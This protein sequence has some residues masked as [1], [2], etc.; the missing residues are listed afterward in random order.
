MKSIKQEVKEILTE[1]EP[2]RNFDGS[3]FLESCK[4]NNVR[5]IFDDDFDITAF[6]NRFNHMSRQRR[7]FQMEKFKDG[8]L[9]PDYE[10]SLVATEKVQS[11]RIRLER[12]FSD[13][14]SANYAFPIEDR[15]IVLLKAE[16]EEALDV[17]KKEVQKEINEIMQNNR[18]LGMQVEN[19]KERS[20]NW[21]EQTQSLTTERNALQD[22]KDEFAKGHIDISEENEKLKAEVKKLQAKLT[23]KH[24]HVIENDQL[25]SENNRLRRSQRNS[26][27]STKTIPRRA[28]PKSS[29][30]DDLRARLANMK[31]S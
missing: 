9:N 16:Y 21:K 5:I 17:H 22:I 24:K 23:V 30:K 27:T 19:W 1:V 12:E 31:K 6:L 20:Q 13:W 15:S 2:A 29:D 11:E 25:K 3:M 4:R 26:R 10:P 7:I 8:K 28:S 14:S 18:R